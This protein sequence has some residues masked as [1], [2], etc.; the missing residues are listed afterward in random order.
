MMGQKS[1]RRHDKTDNTYLSQ[2]MMDA[3]EKQQHK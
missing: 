1:S 2:K 3:R